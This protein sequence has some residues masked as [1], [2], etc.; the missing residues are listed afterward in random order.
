MEERHSHLEKQQSC[1]NNFCEL[2]RNGE[3]ESFTSVHCIEIVLGKQIIDMHLQFIQHDIYELFCWDG[4]IWSN[5]LFLIQ[6]F[7]D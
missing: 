3:A 5:P 1:S 2:D 7:I 4:V 6:S